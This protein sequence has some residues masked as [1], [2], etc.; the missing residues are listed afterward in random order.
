MSLNPLPF[1]VP[2]V[3]YADVV[4]W[5]G[6]H[7]WGPR[8]LY[9]HELLYVLS[10]TLS[11]RLE[12]S[13]HNVGPDQLILIPP[14]ARQQF[15]TGT[16]PH[17]HIGIH[18]DWVQQEDT[19][20][21]PEFFAAEPPY[22]ESLFREPRTV[23]GW[24]TASG[25]VLELGGRPRVR[26]LLM[27]VAEAAAGQ[28]N[29]GPTGVRAVAAGALLAA[30]IAVIGHEADL[31]QDQLAHPQVG[32]DAVRRVHRARELLEQG[33]LPLL[34]VAQV[35]ARVRW[36]PDHLGRM[37]QQVLGTSPSGLQMRA[38][39]QRARQLLRYADSPVPEV[40][41]QCGF[42]DVA[43]FRAVFRREWGVTP[44][45]YARRSD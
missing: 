6:R 11:V 8:V 33:S 34:S 3:R 10:G 4:P 18:F 32:A 22:Q 38:R 25:P 27:Q 45:Q 12:E 28:G 16:G 19:A 41:R 5:P 15:F 42:E 30:A 23:P 43:H 29:C 17:T 20:Q 26:Q 2:Y 39:L 44:G 31:R 13:V 9:D 14:R 37:C 21:F 24:N 36:S 7:S 35:A 1:S 40:A